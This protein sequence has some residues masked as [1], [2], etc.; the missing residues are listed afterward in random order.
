IIIGRR[1]KKKK[2][3]EEIPLADPDNVSSGH[4]TD[5]T[6]EVRDVAHG[7]D[8]KV[9][10]GREEESKASVPSKTLSSS[11]SSNKSGVKIKIVGAEERKSALGK[12]TVYVIEC[13]PRLPVINVPRRYNDFKWLRK[14]LCTLFPGVWMPPL[15][16]AQVLGRFEDQFVLERRDGLER[17]LNK[18][19]EMT[20][21]SEHY[22]FQVFLSRPQETWGEAIKDIEDKFA[23][24]NWTEHKQL[25]SHLH[26]FNPCL[27][28]LD[29]PACVH[30]QDIPSLRQFLLAMENELKAILQLAD[31]ASHH[32]ADM[33]ISMKDWQKSL[34]NLTSRENEYS[35]RPNNMTRV[36][37]Q[38]QMLQWCKFLH[39]QNQGYELFVR[40]LKYE[41]YD[42]SA[43]LELFDQRDHIVAD[44]ERIENKINKTKPEAKTDDMETQ[45]RNLE[46]LLK[47]VT[48]NMLKYQ[49][50]SLWKEKIE[51]FRNAAYLWGT[52]QL[53]ATQDMIHVWSQEKTPLK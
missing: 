19:Q 53:Q 45:K 46:L 23:T 3:M 44:L 36:N 50:D 49:I 41:M 38:P 22:V 8:V 43:F 17:F 11:S 37:L 40:Q 35:F 48:A 26:S 5:V 1:K 28:D 29:L 14:N 47:M 42:I 51:H 13:E 18:I 16:P 25:I 39:D 6:D 2:E 15:P 20:L 52:K 30:K 24:Q 27:R 12:H 31:K 4:L 10:Q 32:L 34:E 33:C 21:I 9:V 7:D